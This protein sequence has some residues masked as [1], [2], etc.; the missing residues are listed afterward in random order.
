MLKA[1][2]S[3][4]IAGAAA[5]A[6][7]SP[8]AAAPV[9][10]DGDGIIYAGPFQN[11]FVGY[12]FDTSQYCDGAYDITEIDWPYGSSF[13]SFSGSSG[14]V[15]GVYL[16]PETAVVTVTDG[17]NTDTFSILVTPCYDDDWPYDDECDF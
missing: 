2:T 9:C 3:L 4:L 13:V 8:A 10:N 15:D 16:S 11:S 14:F 1:L 17:I 7:A 6:I 5:M 12:N